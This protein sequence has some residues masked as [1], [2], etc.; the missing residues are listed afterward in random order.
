MFDGKDKSC[1]FYSLSLITCSIC[2][3]ALMFGNHKSNNP[4]NPFLLMSFILS[5]AFAERKEK[6][7]VFFFILVSLQSQFFS[8]CQGTSISYCFLLWS[9]TMADLCTCRFI[10]QLSTG[11][12]FKTDPFILPKNYWKLSSTKGSAENLYKIN[13][14]K[15]NK[16]TVCS[17]Q[18]EKAAPSKIYVAHALSQKEGIHYQR[19]CQPDFLRMK[20]PKF[21]SGHR[22]NPLTCLTL[23]TSA[24]AG[25]QRSLHWS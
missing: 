17:G 16:N 21:R 25:K 19:R 24:T 20:I 4:P 11:L 5:E 23:S 18:S 8:L 7:G 12:P 3:R 10:P 2:N 13:Y 9:S 1:V 14:K 15:C 6:L 22:E